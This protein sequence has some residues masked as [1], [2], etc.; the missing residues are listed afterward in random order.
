MTKISRLVPL[1]LD[2]ERHLRLDF[3]A[4]CEVERVTG[5]NIYA[6][7]F[8]R[9][10]GPIKTRGVLYAALVHEDNNLTL[11]K[12][13]EL[14]EQNMDKFGAICDAIRDAYSEALPKAKENAPAQ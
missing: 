12:V 10:F 13:G 4:V 9:S 11:E 7:G 2:R 8:W 14:I 1:V 6:P 5:S 3:N